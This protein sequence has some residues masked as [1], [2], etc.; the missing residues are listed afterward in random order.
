M[1]RHLGAAGGLTPLDVD[2]RHK[3]E[4]HGLVRAGRLDWR[5]W[6]NVRNGAVAAPRDDADSLPRAGQYGSVGAPPRVGVPE[7]QGAAERAASA[8]LSAPALARESSAEDSQQR[9]ADAEDAPSSPCTPCDA[10]VALG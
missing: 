4:F 1:R 3:F 2:A 7:G 6:R 9:P 8:A 10:D 5:W